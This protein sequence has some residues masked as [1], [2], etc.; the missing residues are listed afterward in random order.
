MKFLFAV[1]V[2]FS[3][4]ACEQEPA[5]KTVWDEQFKTMDK[6]RDVEKQVLEAADIQHQ[7]IEQQTQQ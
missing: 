4:S 3:L 5:E 7:A 1:V 2:V 6:A